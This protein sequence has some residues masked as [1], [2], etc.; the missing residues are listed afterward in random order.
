MVKK[1]KKYTATTKSRIVIV[2]FVFIVVIATLGYTLFLNLKQVNE[3]KRGL[4]SLEKEQL[5]LLDKEKALEADIK[6]LS[7]PLYVARY[8]REKYFYSKEG[9]LILRIKD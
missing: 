6:R 3:I 1:H 4:N 9:E 2:F 5:T 7:D 8:A